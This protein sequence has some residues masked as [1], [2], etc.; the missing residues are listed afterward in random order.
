M[1]AARIVALFGRDVARG[2]PRRAGA[3]RAPE[4]GQT[5]RRRQYNHHDSR[6]KGCANEVA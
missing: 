1:V 2:K 5:E 6:K 4:R 3:A